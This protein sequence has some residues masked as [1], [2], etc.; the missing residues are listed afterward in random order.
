MKIVSQPVNPDINGRLAAGKKISPENHVPQK[1]WEEASIHLSSDNDNNLLSSN[2]G[3]FAQHERTLF[4]SESEQNILRH[5][6]SY[7]A[8]TS[9]TSQLT[10]HG[11]TEIVVTINPP[12]DNNQFN[13]SI[14][15]NDSYSSI[16]VGMNQEVDDDAEH[17][18]II[19]MEASDSKD[20]FVNSDYEETSDKRKRSARSKKIPK[21]RKK[22]KPNKKELLLKNLIANI[23]EEKNTLLTAINLAKKHRIWDSKQNNSDSTSLPYKKDWSQ[24]NMDEEYFLNQR[25]LFLEKKETYLSKVEKDLKEKKKIILDIESCLL[26]IAHKFM[27]ILNYVPTIEFNTTLNDFSKLFVDKFPFIQGN[28]SNNKIEDNNCNISLNYCDNDISSIKKNNF[29]EDSIFSEDEELSDKNATKSRVIKNELSGLVLIE[30]TIAYN[31]STNECLSQLSSGEHIW[32]TVEDQ[33][34]VPVINYTVDKFSH[35]CVEFDKIKENNFMYLNFNP[36]RQNIK[37]ENCQDLEFEQNKKMKKES[38]PIE[39]NHLKI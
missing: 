15:D 33:C 12:N 23:L 30:N 29:S 21:K 31:S 4:L 5:F 25:E 11:E 27:N 22:I 3:E 26:K 13:S 2:S 1:Q 14:L 28:E 32:T 19:K 6:D 8:S 38:I 36:L 10:V 35:H 16:F 17:D 7:P 39:V 34:K 37:V 20:E 24:N 18:I 9:E